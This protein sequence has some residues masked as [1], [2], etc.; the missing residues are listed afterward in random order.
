LSSDLITRYRSVVA[1]KQGH[2]EGV[3]A[4]ICHDDTHV[5]NCVFEEGVRPSRLKVVLDENFEV[6]A[7][8]TPIVIVL[9]ENFDDG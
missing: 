5:K 3:K 4:K 8:H 7:V 1:T 9:V 2:G 6:V